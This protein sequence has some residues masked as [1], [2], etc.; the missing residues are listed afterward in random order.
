MSDYPERPPYY[1]MR[2]IRWISESGI[3]HEIGVNGFAV[4]VAVV[5]MEDE[6]RYSRP[7]NFYNDQ[8]ARRCGLASEHA[9]IRARKRCEAEGLLVYERGAKRNPGVYYVTGFTAPSAVKAKAT[10]QDSLRLAQGNRRHSAAKAAP[11]IPSP[12]P[13]PKK[14]PE[15]TFDPAKMDLPFSSDAFREAWI[16]FCD[17]RREE[18]KPMTPTAA[19]VALRKLLGWG[20]AVAIS[21][22]ENSTANQWKGLFR[23]DKQRGQAGDHE[24]R[25]PPT[26]PPRHARTDNE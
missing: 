11:S 23:P 12:M 8:L 14:K 7:P 9:L 18:K 19:K 2:Y 3:S 22:L 5:A 10:D 13:M 15:P 1:A 4:L 6:L 16:D 24:Q 26:P 25:T 21:S 20:E 17:M